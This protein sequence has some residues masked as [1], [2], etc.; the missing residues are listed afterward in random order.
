MWGQGPWGG[1]GANPLPG[2]F[3]RLWQQTGGKV[4]GGMPYSEGIYE[5]MNKAIYQQ[6]YWDTDRPA[7]ETVREYL[8][9]EFSPDV[10]DDL[11][12]VVL[13]FETN[14]KRDSIRESALRALEL[15][16]NAEAQLTREVRS[17]WRW[18]I[19]ALRAQIDAELFRREG[20]R[21]GPI[22]KK[23]FEELTAIYHAENSHSMPIH[24]PV[25][26]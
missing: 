8:S 2:R 17:G 7:V 18:R 24:P 26:E 21:E 14:H 9:F 4:S 22:L 16:E 1:Y 23:A 11:L 20:K 10:A 19:F 15:V 25:V 3:Q 6:F 13:I 5:D 12:E